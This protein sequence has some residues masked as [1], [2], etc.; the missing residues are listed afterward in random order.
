MKRGPCTFSKPI[1][2]RRETDLIALDGSP[3]LTDSQSRTTASSVTI[4]QKTGELA[5]MGG[6][7]STY[8]AAGRDSVDLGSGPA[9]ISADSLA[10]STN[11]GHAIYR[12]RS[13]GGGTEKI[14]DLPP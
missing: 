6:V 8:L 2:K 14:H 4:N 9:H 7:A 11:F 3:V 5:A 13:V 10:G 1:A 12:G